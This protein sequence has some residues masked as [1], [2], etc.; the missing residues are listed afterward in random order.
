MSARPPE[1]PAPEGAHVLLIDPDPMA[2]Q[3][4]W[5]QLSGHGHVL[6]VADGA[7]DIDRHCRRG[8]DL[9]LLDPAS[10]GDRPTPAAVVGWDGLRTLRHAHPRLPVIV[11]LHGADAATRTVAFEMGA[12]AVLDKRGHPAELA[13]QVQALLRRCAPPC[14][15]L[16]RFGRWSLDVAQRQVV[17]PD[18]RAIRL[19]PAEA[20]VL[21]ALVNHPRVA[22]GRDQLLALARGQGSAVLARHADRLVSGLRRKLDDD[23]R[24]PTLIRTVAGVGYLFEALRAPD[25]PLNPDEGSGP[26]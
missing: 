7:A 10:R 19:T 24:S 25:G 21:A 4:A 12:D 8:M 3:R 13:A 20:R 5:R 6:H 15:P 18:G 2:R 14:T 1:R 16:L 23:A 9:A 17:T 11:W 22:L 26:P